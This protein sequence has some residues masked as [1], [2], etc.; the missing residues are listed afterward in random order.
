M[1]APHTHTYTHTRTRT[2]THAHAHTL[3]SLLLLAVF[4]VLG[5]HADAPSLE[6]VID[7][8]QEIRRKRKGSVVVEEADP[9]LAATLEGTCCLCP[10][11][12]LVACYALRISRVLCMVEYY[13]SPCCT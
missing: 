8:M 2:H 3:A 13:E 11:A 4:W 5:P 12:C 6:D 10:P 1:S 9:A 7:K